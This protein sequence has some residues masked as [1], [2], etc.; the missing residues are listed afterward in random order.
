MV[1]VM[2]VV[3]RHETAYLERA[4]QASRHH[5]D[6]PRLSEEETRSTTRDLWGHE[7]Q[8]TNPR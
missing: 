7:N 4:K 8:D 6:L 2:V 3:V 1:M 5:V